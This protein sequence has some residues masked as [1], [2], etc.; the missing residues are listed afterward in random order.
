MSLTVCISSLLLFM[1]GLQEAW[2]N[3]LAFSLQQKTEILCLEIHVQAVVVGVDILTDKWWMLLVF[4][5]QGSLFLW[6]ELEAWQPA[7]YMFCSLAGEVKKWN[8][9]LLYEV[10]DSLPRSLAIIFFSAFIWN[11]GASSFS[12][13]GLERRE[14]V[15]GFG[16]VQIC[17]IWAVGSAP[18]GA[19]NSEHPQLMLPNPCFMGCSCFKGWLITWEV[20]H[21]TLPLLLD[22]SVWCAGCSYFTREGE[23]IIQF[24]STCTSVTELL[25][26][27]FS[28]CTLPNFLA[29]KEFSHSCCVMC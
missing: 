10:S 2:E 21:G 7:G 14:T 17:S 16:D 8:Q 19:V 3:S 4:Q 9:K 24:N 11:A 23:V 15:H 1:A 22:P 27:Y 12:E 20:L 25:I 13:K 5:G 6:Q 29:L 18:L 28:P 26:S